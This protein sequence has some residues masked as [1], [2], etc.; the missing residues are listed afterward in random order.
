MKTYLYIGRWQPLHDNH[1]RLIQKGLDDGGNVVVGI[2]AT[3]I[4][5]KNPLRVDAREK[6]I[7]SKFGDKVSTVVI[8][9]PDCD[10]VVRVGRRVGYEVQYLEEE[11]EEYLAA[12]K[13]ISGTKLRE[14]MRVEG[15]LS[16]K[17]LEGVVVWLTGTSGAGKTT[18]A[19]KLAPFIDADILDGEDMR[20]SISADM[21][22]TPQDRHEH[23]LRVARLAKVLSE[24]KRNVIVSVIAPLA[25]TRRS[26]SE[27]VECVWVHV[28]R[29]SWKSSTAKVYQAP[30]SPD[31]V[32]DGDEQTPIEEAMSILKYIQGRYL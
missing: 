4:D 6:M 17:K 12:G 16:D 3:K 14:Q 9:D 29:D 21:G 7:F 19:T 30:L 8:P 22:F 27:I 24:Q 15:T 2:R 26:I 28:K 11:T 25:E 32:V 13:G 23:N 31:L 18:I 10:L 1:I 5:D 20:Y